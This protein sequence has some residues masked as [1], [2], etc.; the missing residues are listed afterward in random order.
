[1]QPTTSRLAPKPIRSR[2]VIPIDLLAPGILPRPE[3]PL[4][5]LSYPACMPPCQPNPQTPTRALFTGCDYVPPETFSSPLPAANSSN[6]VRS[7]PIGGGK[8]SYARVLSSPSYSMHTPPR[9]KSFHLS[10]PRNPDFSMRCHRCLARDHFVQECRDPFRCRRCWQVGHAQR[11]CV[12]ILPPPSLGSS[13]TPS[14]IPQT[15]SEPSSPPAPPPGRSSSSIAA[16][17]ADFIPVPFEISSSSE[18]GELPSPPP[19]PHGL[20]TTT[21]FRLP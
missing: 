17:M 11:H 14:H 1:M 13:S 8:E 2:R 5:W 16:P 21:R 19:P 18:D 15:P 10:I 20:P 4:P 9:L 6:P 12:A 3:G 7:T